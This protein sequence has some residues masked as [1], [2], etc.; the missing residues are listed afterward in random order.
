MEVSVLDHI[1]IAQ[2]LNQLATQYR[3]AVLVDD[4]TN[5]QCYPIVGNDHIDVIILPIG[6]SAKTL[7]VAQFVWSS[8]IDFGYS[9]NDYLVTLGGGS[10]CDLGGFVA[11]TYMRGIHLVH[12]PTS[13]LAMVDASIGGKTAIDFGGIKN[14]VG[15]FYNP[16]RVWV[17][18]D[19]L[20]TLKREELV[21][22]WAELY[23]YG[24]LIGNGYL[25]TIQDFS[26]ITSNSIASAIQYKLDIVAQ[27]FKDE[28]IRKYLNLGHTTGHALEAL[29]LSR[30]SIL[31]HGKAVA[32]GLVIALYI[33]YRYCG[34]EQSILT[35]NARNI[36][37]LFPK[38]SYLCD[39]YE[40]LWQFA[41]KDKKKANNTELTMVLLKDVSKPIV[42]Q[43][44]RSEWEEALDFYRDFMG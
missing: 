27:D 39:D 20:D 9:R 32:C 36:K 28:G 35:N 12:I 17:S 21:N 10:I 24:L 5:E 34:L 7:E 38:V 42:K 14:S 3:V 22:G 25:S 18:I 33:S 1:T 6:E 31:P 41:L 4:N 37:K 15:T 30:N 11:S 23:K 8:L 16:E 2:K 19:F 29:Y 40:T 43:V 44:T 13:L 26:C